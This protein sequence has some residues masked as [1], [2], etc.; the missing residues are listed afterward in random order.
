MR[1]S[2]WEVWVSRAAVGTERIT[3]FPWSRFY[4]YRLISHQPGPILGCGDVNTVQMRSTTMFC[5]SKKTDYA[6][7][8]LA[9]LSENPQRI[10]SAREIAEAYQLPLPLLMNI[11]KTLHQQGILLSIRGSN[12]GYQLAVN[13]STVS[14]YDLISV[15]ERNE[16]AARVLD[17]D[18]AGPHVP[19]RRRAKLAGPVAAPIEALHYKFRRFLKEVKLS[20]LLTPGRRID[21]PLERVRASERSLVAPAG[22]KQPTDPECVAPSREASPVGA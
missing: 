11:L 6:L 19:E 18:D 7:I 9:Y 2:N 12:G 1:K 21:V 8:G 14:L 13:P 10:A 5:L 3:R 17:L 22:K 15:L 20:D 16:P 4:R